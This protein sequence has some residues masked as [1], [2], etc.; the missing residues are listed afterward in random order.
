MIDIDPVTYEFVISIIRCRLSP[1]FIYHSIKDTKNRE[2]LLP[3]EV[4][5]NSLPLKNGTP[6]QI[7][8]FGEISMSSVLDPEKKSNWHTWGPEWSALWLVRLVCSKVKSA[9]IQKITRE[10]KVRKVSKRT[11]VD[12]VGIRLNYCRKAQTN[13]F[14][15][16]YERKN[17]F[18]DLNG[19]SLLLAE[20]GCKDLDLKIIE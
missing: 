3:N 10:V 12:S 16:F 9:K 18:T 19:E 14:L 17:L 1:L 13:S 15:S 2:K 7:R 5:W 6:T 8:R 20:N 4:V 11:I